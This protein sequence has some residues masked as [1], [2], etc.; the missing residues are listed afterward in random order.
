MAGKPKEVV[1]ASEMVK[2][3]MDIMMDQAEVDGV[4][5]YLDNAKAGSY[6]CAHKGMNQGIALEIIGNMLAGLGVDPGPFMVAIAHSLSTQ[7]LK[8]RPMAGGLGSA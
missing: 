2:V 8:G 7:E 6:I 5:V 4:M 1:T 3:F